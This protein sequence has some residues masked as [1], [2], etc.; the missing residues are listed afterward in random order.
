VYL[1][2]ARH[3]KNV[4]G[5]KTDVLDCQ[6]IQQLHTYGLLSASFRPEAD[7]VALRSYIRH[8]DN[9][10]RYR[11][12]HIQH[13]LKALHWMNIKLSTVI[14][15][16]TGQTGQKIIRAII[17]GEHDPVKL[18]QYRNNRCRSSENEIAKALTGHYLAEHLFVL[19]QAVELYDFYSQQIEV[20]DTE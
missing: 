6:W 12:V 15:D 1:I 19:K 14:S 18:A 2:N 10:I 3:I 8:R 5:K 9:L 7:M 11:S 20:C 16:I 17:A 13:M 4:P